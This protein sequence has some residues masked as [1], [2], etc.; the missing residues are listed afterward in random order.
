MRRVHPDRVH[1]AAFPGAF[2]RQFALTIAASTVISCF[3]SLTLSPA[4]AALLLRPHDRDEQQ[5]GFMRSLGAPINAV[6]RRLQP[7]VR[8]ALVAAMA[9]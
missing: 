9:R 1:H 4:L 6:L 8:A 5:R 7:G 3:V 2:Y